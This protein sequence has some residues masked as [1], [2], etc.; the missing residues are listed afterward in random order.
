MIFA[1]NVLL[2]VNHTLNRAL[3]V[4]ADQDAL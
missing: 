4:F 1:D 2:N 3:F